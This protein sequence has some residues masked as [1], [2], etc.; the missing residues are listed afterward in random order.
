MSPGIRLLFIVQ[1]VLL[2]GLIGQI[3]LWSF[4]G[5][6]PPGWL[7]DVCWIVISAGFAVVWLAQAVAEPRSGLRWLSWGLAA[8]GVIA[9][10]FTTL[11]LVTGRFTNMASVCTNAL[12]FLT[13]AYSLFISARAARGKRI[14]Q[15]REP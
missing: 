1:I 13:L 6:G 4:A 11:E 15:G 9:V 8:L 10:A 2:V 12:V 3:A 5:T 14:H 7:S